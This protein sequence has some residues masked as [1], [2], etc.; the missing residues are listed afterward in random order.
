MVG[1]VRPNFGSRR[2]CGDN[3]RC[4]GSSIILTQKRRAALQGISD[5]WLSRD[6]AG[7]CPTEAKAERGGRCDYPQAMFR[8]NARCRSLRLLVLGVSS[9]AEVKNSTFAHPQL[10]IHHFGKLY[11]HPELPKM[12]YS[13][14]RNGGKASGLA[15]QNLSRPAGRFRHLRPASRTEYRCGTSA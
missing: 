15:G 2:G 3:T 5:W 9:S 14:T 12:E 1:L 11:I 6:S 7:N 4:C 13:V 10:P 8:D